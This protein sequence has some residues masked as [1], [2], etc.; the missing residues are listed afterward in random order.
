MF[1][2]TCLSIIYSYFS[3]AFK[4]TSPF[5]TAIDSTSS[6]ITLIGIMILKTKRILSNFFLFN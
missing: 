3:N 1:S 2:K 4:Y 5:M 6:I